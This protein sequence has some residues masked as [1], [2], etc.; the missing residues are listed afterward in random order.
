M[1]LHLTRL[2]SEGKEYK[3]F[4]KKMYVLDDDF[5]DSLVHFSAALERS[6]ANTRFISDRIN[7]LENSLNN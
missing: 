4:V 2:H 1:T 3:S 7:D 6:L 5:N